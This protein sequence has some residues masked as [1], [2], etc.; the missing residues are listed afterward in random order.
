MAHFRWDYD[1]AP[2][3]TGSDMALAPWGSALESSGRGPKMVWRTQSLGHS[4]QLTHWWHTH[5]KEFPN[6]LVGIFLVSIFFRDGFASWRGG[7]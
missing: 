6:Q 7:S 5:L 2:E 3:P 4:F 1:G